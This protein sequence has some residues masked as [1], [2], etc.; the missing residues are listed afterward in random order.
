MTKE[1]NV[2]VVVR[3]RPKNKNET[4]HSVAVEVIEDIGQIQVSDP[5][6]NSSAPKK[7]TFDHVF[8]FNSKQVDLYNIVARPIVDSVLEGYNGTIF[9]YGQTGTGKTFT[10]EGDRS[11]PELK[12]I[13]PNSF[14]HIFGAIAE[15]CKGQDSNNIQYVVYASFMEIYNEQIRDL[16]HNDQT[17]RLELKDNPDG[18]VYVKN[19]SKQPAESADELNRL[20]TI[21]NKHRSVGATNMNEHSSR[22]HAI[23][24]ITIECSENV[25]SDRPQIRQ[26]KLNLVDLAGSE[27]QSK[28]GASGER[29]KEAVNINLSLSTLSRVISALVDKNS[30]YI[31]YR[32]SK[33]TRYL[34]DSLGGNSKTT[35]I[36]NIGPAD[37]NVDET[38]GTLRYANRA[39]NI[40]NQARINEDPKDT[41]LRAMVDEIAKLKKKLEEGG[42]L[43]DSEYEG[44]DDDSSSEEEIYDEATGQM[45]KKP[46]TKKKRSKSKN[47][48]PKQKMTKEQID[49]AQDQI[50]AEKRRLRVDNK[51]ADEEKQKAVKI[52]QEKEAKLK[53]AEKDQA[54]LEAKLKRAQGRILGAQGENLIDKHTAQEKLLNEANLEVQRHQ[55]NLQK[56][57]AS[58]E[59]KRIANIELEEEYKNLKEEAIGKGRK[60]KQ[61]LSHLAVVKTECEDMKATHE[62]E[63][64]IL[65]ENCQEL[66]KQIG[67]AKLLIDEYIPVEYQRQI[68]EQ[69]TYN[70]AIGEWQLNG[71]AYTGNN[72]LLSQKHLQEKNDKEKENEATLD[73]SGVYMSYNETNLQQSSMGTYYN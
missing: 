14:A 31:P 28:T 49:A 1:D 30:N 9:A 29:L 2:K 4:Q 52:L 60:I 61:I 25:S 41:M 6:S 45:I 23:F 13:I 15:K 19:L 54:E 22:S 37:Y 68:Q 53:A 20:M 12:G 72:M 24:S 56:T 48:K 50:E 66:S 17:K 40:K 44:M 57:K 11:I 3:C 16:L 73:L 21:G 18:G 26:G 70:E 64:G 63:I 27:R 7:Y 39:K 67:L 65:M 10:M 71:V 58:I 43:S 55:Q 59:E 32:E 34:Q 51:L 5:K 35:M 38:L 47:K 62:Q 42:S 46:K 69:I 36:A 8:G 33:L